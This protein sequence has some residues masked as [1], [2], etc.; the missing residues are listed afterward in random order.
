MKTDRQIA[1]EAIVRLA[2][3]RG[4]LYAVR[5]AVIDGEDIDID[6]INR[7]CDETKAP[8]DWPEWTG[9]WHEHVDN[10]PEMVDV[11]TKTK[12]IAQLSEDRASLDE[13][14][15][16]M[17]QHMKR[18][19]SECGVEPAETMKM[20]TDLAL[21]AILS[22][23]SGTRAAEVLRGYVVDLAMCVEV[24]RN[25][26]LKRKM[27]LMSTPVIDV[28]RGVKNFILKHRPDDHPTIIS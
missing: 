18:V 3:A 13:D 9:D 27:E 2:K 15:V 16:D 21:S 20:T 7:I 11:A 5:L 12:T 22:F 10:S 4:Q 14:F 1:I 6:A 23:K 24:G 8:E 26:G 25:A 28:Y 19:L 17:W